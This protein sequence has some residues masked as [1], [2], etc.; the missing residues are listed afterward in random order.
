MLKTCRLIA[1]TMRGRFLTIVRQS[2]NAP[3]GENPYVRS[4][5]LNAQDGKTIS[6]AVPQR[7][8][9]PIGHF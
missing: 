1:S 8:P 4:R 7:V 6:H 5:N 3:I 2:R 9:T